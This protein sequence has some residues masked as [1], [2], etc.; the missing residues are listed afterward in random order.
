MFNGQ[1]ISLINKGVIQ[2][3][4]LSPTLFT[5]FMDDLLIRLDKAGYHVFAYA[6]DIAITGSGEKKLLKAWQT[7]WNW[8]LDSQMAVN[9]KKSGIMVHQGTLKKLVT[10]DRQKVH[11]RSGI[12]TV[13][14]YKYLGVIFDRK[15]NFKAHVEHV[16]EVHVDLLVPPEPQQPQPQAPEPA[17]AAA[18]AAEARE[19]PR[20][21]RP[22]RRLVRRQ[23]G[24]GAAERWAA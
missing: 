7:I 17:R 5:V 18:Q 15:L 19:S 23:R 14:T 20:P 9:R 8:Q 16:R 11:K 1:D 2:G 22:R 13:E 4:T 21:E 3:G 10:V 24:R 12:P 6:D